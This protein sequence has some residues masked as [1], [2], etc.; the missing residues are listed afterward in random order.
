MPYAPMRGFTYE[1]LCNHVARFLLLT[2]A[3]L[4]VGCQ[5]IASAKERVATTRRNWPLIAIVAS[6]VLCAGLLFGVLR[7]RVFCDDELVY[8]MQARF[9]TEGRIA[10]DRLGFTP[11]EAFTI[12]SLVGYTGKYLPGE[13]VVQMLGVLVGLPALMHLP[14]LVATLLLWRRTLIE[15]SGEGFAGLAVVALAVSP[16]LIFTSAT[17]LSQGSALF[18]LVLAGYGLSRCEQ[19]APRSGATLVAVGLGFAL[20]CRPQSALPAAC[21]LGPLVL[22]ALY[23]KRSL[24]GTALLGLSSAAL[25]GL[26]LAY[27]YRLTGHALRLPW[28]LQ[29]SSEHYGF[30]RVWKTAGFAHTPWSGLENLAVVA[31]RLNAWWLGLPAS[32]LVLVAWIGQGRRVH[33]QARWLWVGLAVI[34]FEFAY[35]SPGVSDTGAIYHFELLLPGSIIAASVAQRIL[36]QWGRRGAWAMGSVMLLGA[37]SFQLEQ[38]L[39]MARL[40]TAVHSDSDRALASMQKPALLFHEPWWPEAHYLA[41]AAAFPRR[42]RGQADGVVNFPRLPEPFLTRVREVY[43][44][45]HCYYYHRRG[46][47]EAA[48]LLRCEDAQAYLRRELIPK[49]DGR[50]ALWIAPTAYKKTDFDPFSAL[51][52]DRIRDPQGRALGPCCA[53]EEL[54][55][56]GMNTPAEPGRTCVPDGPS[57]ADVMKRSR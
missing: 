27:N 56:F 14:L 37:G 22:L 10:D 34:L 30:G 21:V 20:L 2:P 1:Q 7:G 18:G 6:T 12:P 36:E 9:L 23:R 4:L 35:Y 46:D 33:G 47:D 29:C 42:F 28:Y 43:P 31:V 13:P 24:A 16:M 45:R 40:M 49:D 55:S 51:A 26:V 17:G 32:L 53:L 8:A 19:D 15:R 39:R 41:W 5:V 3:L 48:E 50:R 11:P 25:V 54:Q 57:T 44:N 52:K 38:F